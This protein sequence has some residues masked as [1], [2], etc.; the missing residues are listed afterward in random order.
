VRIVSLDGMRLTVVS[1][2]T[3]ARTY[4]R[5]NALLDSINRRM[6]FGDPFTM[7]IR[8]AAA[9]DDDR[10]LLSAPGVIYVRD[11]PKAG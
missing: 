5:L 1:D 11:E 4:V 9:L 8:E 2:S 7:A 3:Q 10:A 6:F